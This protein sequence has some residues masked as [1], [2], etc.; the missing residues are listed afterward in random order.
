MFMFADCINVS[1]HLFY[2]EAMS[3][4][5]THGHNASWYLYGF[6]A[7]KER[8]RRWEDHETRPD[9]PWQSEQQGKRIF[10]NKNRGYFTFD[11]ATQAFGDPP[12]S[13][14]PDSEFK[15]DLRTRQNPVIVDFGDSFFLKEMIAG[16]G[17]GDVLDSIPFQ[18]RDTLYSVL[19]FYT[20]EGAANVHAQSWYDQNYIILHVDNIYLQ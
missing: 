18:N 1:A 9:L 20:L 11:P 6:L 4:Y 15:A 10:W 2:S 16:I 12:L 14:I 3:D 8:P 13:D 5:R 7:W 17:Y 19:F